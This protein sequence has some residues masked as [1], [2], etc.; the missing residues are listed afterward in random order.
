MSALPAPATAAG[1]PPNA[2]DAIKRQML[3]PVLL[4]GLVFSP[5]VNIL[6]LTSSLYMMQVFDRV[7]T[8]QSIDTLLFL[9]IIA[10]GATALMAA[11]ELV[12]GRIMTRL[13]L[14][15]ETK[16][17]SEGISRAIE[18]TLLGREY[19]SEVLR[20]LATVR[21][22]F[23][24]PSTLN[25]F[26]VPWI[27]IYLIVV[28]LLNWKLGALALS[29]LILLSFLAWFNDRVTSAPLK[30]S[31]IKAQRSFRQAEAAIRNAEALDVM[32]MTPGLVRRWRADS[33]AA[34]L[35]SLAAAD[36]SGDVMAFSK[37]ARLGLQLMVMALGAHLALSRELTSG[38]MIA[39]SI[40]IS[41]AL[42]PIE[43]AIGSWKYTL[44]TWQSYLRLRET[45]ARPL[46]RASSM[47]LPKPTGH[48]TAEG[49]TFVPPG[50]KFPVIKGMSFEIKPGQIV[51]IVGPSAAGKSTLARLCVGAYPPAHG[52]VRLD[53]ADVFLW[54][55]DDFSTYVG[56]LPQDIELFAGT[57]RENISR[58][59][60]AEPSE[61]VEAAQMAGAHEMILRLPQGYETEIGEGG[62]LLSGGQRQRIGLARAL[63]R[64][65]QF[66]VLDEPNSSLDSEGEEA[67]NRAIAKMKERGATVLLIGHRPSIL[68]HVDSIMVLRDGR[69]ELM[70][71]KAEVLAKIM[72]TAAQRVTTQPPP[73]TGEQPTAAAPGRAS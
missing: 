53:G 16:L 56:Y 23:T 47:S 73:A 11:I 49:I 24:N 20:D 64:N 63:F 39:C 62:V 13:G 8:S 29:G 59:M 66:I 68:Q 57:V 72:P 37:F 58:L 7:M 65:P 36:R 34:H 25:L 26:D 3:R 54:N 30:E 40:I 27:P 28:A 50:G 35:S 67:L 14:W 5:I 38:G 12:R 32:G 42:A 71:P 51:A 21:N 1:S 33:D 2:V 44:A 70:G 69:I 48:L 15:L 60:P 18:A 43:A 46:L 6:V 52:N 41:R 10:L 55:R 4:I 17:A 61:V 45:Y 9:T 19:R 31:N 22:F